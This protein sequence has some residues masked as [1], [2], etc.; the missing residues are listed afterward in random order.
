MIIS[1]YIDKGN[2]K[3]NIYLENFLEDFD[4]NSMEKGEE[5]YGNNKVFTV[6]QNKDIG[7][8]TFRV[9]VTQIPTVLVLTWIVTIR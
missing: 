1:L 2:T 6:S 9:K 5:L 8:F 4:Y 3:M 7:I